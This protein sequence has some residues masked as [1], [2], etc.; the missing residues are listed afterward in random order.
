MKKYVTCLMLLGLFALPSKAD[1]FVNAD[2]S[3]ESAVCIDAAKSSMNIKA[4][5]KKYKMSKRQINAIAC[6]GLLL[7][8]FVTKY[9]AKLKSGAQVK[10]FAFSK[11]VGNVE[12]ELCIAAATSNDVLKSA[13][14]KHK[15]TRLFVTELTCNK[16]PIKA[17]AKKYGNKQFSI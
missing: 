10:V 12:T 13:M 3:K 8:E 15:K 11:E 7:P 4:L 16:M 2:G 17:F 6:N 9:E 5:Q 14:K 1:S